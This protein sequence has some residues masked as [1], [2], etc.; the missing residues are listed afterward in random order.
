MQTAEGPC[1]N[2][3]VALFSCLLPSLTLRIIF[4][5]LSLL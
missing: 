3:T 4:P 2:T 1:P 5:F